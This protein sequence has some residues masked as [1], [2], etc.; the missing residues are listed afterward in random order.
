VSNR[1]D[2]GSRLHW[3]ETFGTRVNEIESRYPRRLPPL[4]GGVMSQTNVTVPTL[5]QAT[6]RRSLMESGMRREVARAR[7][8]CRNT[9]RSCPKIQRRGCRGITGRHRNRLRLR[10]VAGDLVRPCFSWTCRESKKTNL[11]SFDT[12]QDRAEPP[13]GGRLEQPEQPH[14]YGGRL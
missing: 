12:E 11:A 14:R 13:C 10:C 1:I 5:V 6:V 7:P 4:L 2:T 3:A 8:N 9:P